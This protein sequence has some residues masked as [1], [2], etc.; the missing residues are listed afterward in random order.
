[1]SCSLTQQVKSFKPK[2]LA[3]QARSETSAPHRPGGVCKAFKRVL[4]AACRSRF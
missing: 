4:H 2:L 1:M 3:W